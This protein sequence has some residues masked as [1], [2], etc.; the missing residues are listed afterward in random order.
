[1]TSATSRAS[2]GCAARSVNPSGGELIRVVASDLVHAALLVEAARA[3]RVLR[4]DAE[5]RLPEPA[6]AELA[7]RVQEGR[8]RAPAAP[9]GTPDGEIVAPALVGVAAAP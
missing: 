5:P 8:G 2:S 7:E 1:M 4:V 6:R 3:C 9:P